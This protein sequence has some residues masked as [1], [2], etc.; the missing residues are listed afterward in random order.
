M[1]REYEEDEP[2]TCRFSVLRRRDATGV[3]GI[4]HVADGAQFA[5]GTVVVRWR[6]AYPTTTTYTSMD[7]V[8][9][10][11]GHSGMTTFVWL[12]GVRGVGA[13]NAM[14]DGLENA[15]N[16]SVGLHV[17]ALARLTLP[18]SEWRAPDTVPEARRRLWLEGY[19]DFEG[20]ALLEVTP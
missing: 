14:L 8:R 11:H 9:A 3:S 4:G 17:D 19:A 1:R 13:E 10:I 20:V 2:S 7:A 18:P 6:G 15:R 16:G 5:D 12:D